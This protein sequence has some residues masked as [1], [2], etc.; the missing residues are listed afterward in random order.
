M[1][2]RRVL[3]QRLVSKVDQYNTAVQFYNQE[4]NM[5]AQRTN[6]FLLTQS[7][8]LVALVTFLGKAGLFPYALVFILWGISLLGSVF[9]LLH[10]FAGRNGAMAALYWQQCMEELDCLPTLWAR[11]KRV[12]EDVS[13]HEKHAQKK[14]LCNLIPRMLCW[15]CLLDKPPFP[16]SW[17]ITPWLFSLVWAGVS[18][19]ILRRYFVNGDPLFANLSSFISDG[20]VHFASIGV[21]VV[22]SIF[23][24]TVLCFLVYWKCKKVQTSTGIR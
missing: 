1:V 24:F 11:V 18:A 10:C 3:P 9:C 16:S 17:L 20:W 7:I 23:S 21:V 22:T 6:V 4:I 12:S 13:K 14:N 2:G 19:Y 8:L 5:I 15:R